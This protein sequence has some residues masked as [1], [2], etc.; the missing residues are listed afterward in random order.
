MINKLLTFIKETLPCWHD[1]HIVYDMHS[2]AIKR[3]LYCKAGIVKSF[4]LKRC[5]KC[6]RDK[7]ILYGI[8]INQ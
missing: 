7:W 5:S 8:I 1:D 3:T 4:Y 2:I 6:Y